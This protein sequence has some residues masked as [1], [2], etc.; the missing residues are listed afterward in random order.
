MPIAKQIEFATRRSH[1][2]LPD[3]SEPLGLMA[4][5]RLE[6]LGEIN[7]LA[8]YEAFVERTDRLEISLEAPK[9]PRADSVPYWKS[10]CKM[11]PPRRANWTHPWVNGNGRFEAVRLLLGFAFGGV[12]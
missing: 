4:S 3:G 9:Q 12:L 7:I 8:T 2:S 11:D 6:S 1:M 10:A 5:E